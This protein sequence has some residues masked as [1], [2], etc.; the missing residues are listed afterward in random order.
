LLEVQLPD[1]RIISYDHDPLGRRIAKRMD[2]AIVETYLW[3]GLTNLLAVYD[4][5]N[6]LIQRFKY[7][8]SR[9]P[10]SM[11]MERVTYYLAGL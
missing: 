4:G 3:Q 9:M 10:V 1:G 5:A 8:D 7:A 6:N 2:G 11:T